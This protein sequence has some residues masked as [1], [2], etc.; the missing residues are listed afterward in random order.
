MRFTYG[1]NSLN[2]CVTLYAYHIYL[3]LTIKSFNKSNVPKGEMS[4]STDIENQP[5]YVYTLNI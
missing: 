4:A 1:S 5:F 2:L 3:K